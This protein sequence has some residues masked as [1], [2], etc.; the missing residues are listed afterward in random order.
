MQQ[1]QDRSRNTENRSNAKATGQKP[2]SNH[3]FVERSTADQQIEK[4]TPSLQQIEKEPRLGSR[5]KKRR[6]LCSRSKKS[7]DW[8]LGRKRDA[9]SAVMCPPHG[10]TASRPLPQ[11]DG[12]H[13][14]VG[15][16]SAVEEE[17]RRASSSGR[18][19]PDRTRSQPNGT[20]R[21][22]PPSRCPGSVRRQVVHT[23][24]RVAL[25]G[26][27]HRCEKGERVIRTEGTQ[28]GSPRPRG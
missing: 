18:V 4:E 14:V 3:Q 27:S 23:S 9:V 19:R 15:A 8:V 11:Q 5:S 17:G 24:V 22:H 26:N 6:C 21:W 28:R 7:P 25:K 10:E 12:V 13:H 2:Q 16:P 1:Q 20:T